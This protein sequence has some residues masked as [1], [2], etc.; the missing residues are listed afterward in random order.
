M[1]GDGKKHERLQGNQQITK[2]KERDR[3]GQPQS[4]EVGE[5][6]RH[7]VLVWRDGGQSDGKER[8][9]GVKGLHRM[10]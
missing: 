5:G 2:S 7:S 9:G 8:L 6:V 1:V 3:W 4:G 10:P